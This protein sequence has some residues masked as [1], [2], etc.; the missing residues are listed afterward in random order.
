MKKNSRFLAMAT[1]VLAMMTAMTACTTANDDNPLPD[2]LP[3]PEKTTT[4][5]GDEDLREGNEHCY[6]DNTWTLTKK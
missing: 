3:P 1:A 4:R 5:L 6:D 2:T